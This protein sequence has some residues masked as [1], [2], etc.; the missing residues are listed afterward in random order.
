MQFFV[1]F[2]KTFIE[3]NGIITLQKSELFLV[4]CVHCSI[5]LKCGHDGRWTRY[6]NYGRHY[7]VFIFL[8]IKAK[9]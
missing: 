5:K 3:N 9:T 4:L 6:F 8:P 2:G 1:A 7:L